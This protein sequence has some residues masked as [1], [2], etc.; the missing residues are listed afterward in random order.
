MQNNQT[1]IWFNCILPHLKSYLA[2]PLVKKGTN[3]N[4]NDD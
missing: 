2:L 3:S 4:K 1:N